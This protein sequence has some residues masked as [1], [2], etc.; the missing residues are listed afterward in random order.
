[1]IQVHFPEKAMIEDELV[2]GIPEEGEIR[3]LHRTVSDF[4]D[5]TH[6]MMD[7]VT[8]NDGFYV[9]HYLAASILWSFKARSYFT[10]A[11]MQDWHD[12]MPTLK[13]FWHYCQQAESDIGVNQIRYVNGMNE[14]L[15][16]YWLDRKKQSR[17]PFKADSWVDVF[18]KSQRDVARTLDKDI[19]DP[20]LA[21]AVKYELRY[22]VEWRN[23]QPPK[24]SSTPEA[25][26]LTPPAIDK[27]KQ[28]QIRTTTEQ[29]QF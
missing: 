12:Y 24:V 4:L 26:D 2:E 20:I 16:K 1:L 13:A 3:L 21:L 28:P 8:R 15:Q 27:P 5:E 17:H 11:T 23:A 7:S 18:L 22:Y 9:D 6:D 25:D 14:V 19:S 29:G 10:L